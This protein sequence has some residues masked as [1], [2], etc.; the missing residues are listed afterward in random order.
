MRSTFTSYNYSYFLKYSLL[1]ALICWFAS[2]AFAQTLSQKRISLQK[3]DAKL[4][5]VLQE[6]ETQGGFYFSYD[7]S[8]VKRDSL[9]TVAVSNQTVYGVLQA[10]FGQKF[11]YLEQG[12]YLIITPALPRLVLANTDVIT[13]GDAVSVSG[14]VTDERSGERLMNASVYEKE[15]LVAALTDEHGYFK[16]NL[17]CTF[18]SRFR[19]ML[20]LAWELTLVGG[21]AATG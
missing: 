19:L 18:C 20:G 14:L 9:V 2:N 13:D 12:K 3:K 15:Q 7:G 4:S 17:P 16:L 11:E 8:L 1:T 5:V 10:L 21:T 6:I